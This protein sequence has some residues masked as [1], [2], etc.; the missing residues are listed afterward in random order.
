MSLSFGWSPWLLALCALV[1]AG[2]T[3]WSYRRTVPEVSTGRRA[4]LMG[5]RF[6][7]LFVV[8][9]L[10]FEPIWRTLDRDERPPLLAVL[11]DDSQSLSLTTGTEDDSLRLSDAVRE[12]VRTLPRDALGGNVRFFAFD[13]LV[14]RL[15]DDGPA[16]SLRFDGS[17]TDMAQALDVVRDELRDQN[18]G[19][20]LL[21]SDGQYNTGRNPLYRADRYPVPI[22]T[23][24]VGDTTR[25]RDL[26]IRRVTTNDIAYVGT[27]LP[28]QVGLR[29]Q[30]FGGEQ[31]VVSLTR[32]GEQV[33]SSSLRLPEGTAE[34]PVDLTYTPQDVGFQ[35][36]V[37]SVTRLPG[38]VTHR[39]NTETF[40]VRAMESKRRLLVLG[41]APS[42]DFANVRQLLQQDPNLEVTTFVQKRPGTF[43]EGSL[44]ADLSAFDVMVLVG[45]PGRLADDAA[46]RRLAE[47]AEAGTPLLFLLTRQTDLDHL[48]QHFADVLPVAPA[49]PRTTFAE[50]SMVVTARGAQHPILEAAEDRRQ[51]GQLPPLY[52]NESRW[53]ASPD[54]RV[55]AT[56]DV[57]G[58]ELD[59]PM[60]VVRQRTDTRSAALLGA[61]TWRWKNLPEDL[62]SLSGFW[63]RLF[64]NLVQWLT[65]PDDDRR[66]RVEPVRDV[67]S[68][69]EPVEMTG[70]V[71]DESLN[72]V[73]D[74]SVA[75][76]VTA[77][78][79]TTYP[80][81]MEPVGNGRYVLEAGTLPEGTYQ[82]EAAAE[83]NGVALGTDRGSFAVGAL[84]LEFKETQANAAL[85][86]Q[87]AQ[88]SG[89]QFL[90]TS[91]LATLPDLLR[92]SERFQPTVR[93]ETR[94]RELWRL[95][96][97]LGLIVL[98]LSTEWFLRKRSGMV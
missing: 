67:F 95:P 4:V 84:T 32:G 12:T 29:T 24:A 8:L 66:V 54:A 75:V 18:L 20:V 63:P 50:A 10:L 73:D 21:I 87:I 78:D 44:P 91:D 17:R 45:Y 14:E 83:R 74:A 46:M 92:S 71:Y 65:T 9:F 3:Y 15:P 31:V 69:S 49:R 33:A 22:Y 57:R 52:M 93:E 36:L 62:E 81:T 82:Y 40:T 76:E 51:L 6:L 60:L 35:Q 25:R 56:V 72:P 1:A 97:L 59:D 90:P 96:W 68:G 23:V 61:G 26:Q 48:R 30:D 34:V 77:P 19:G 47:A 38:E 28:V 53:E 70:Q 7:A 58:V 94:E 42:P 80:Y 41:A 13:A 89:G 37:V 55:L 16:D 43:Y 88:R 85:L 2:L 98:L 39:N 64:S 5:L 79:S 11:V 27:E 86:R